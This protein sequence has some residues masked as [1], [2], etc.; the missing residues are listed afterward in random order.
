MLEF[1]CRV[2]LGV[3]VADF[4]QLQGAFHGN[5]VMR[6]AAQEEGV[7]AFGKVLGPGDE[8]RL[9]RQHRLQGGG[10]MAHGF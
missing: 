4:F 10:Q 8:L 6:A 1:A 2:G 7:L 5:R 3:D 9:Q